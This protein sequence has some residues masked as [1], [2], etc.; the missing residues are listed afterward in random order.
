MNRF[1]PHGTHARAISASMTPSAR[2]G[3]AEFRE[4]VVAD[5]R[6]ADDVTLSEAKMQIER[7]RLIMRM[8]AQID[9]MLSDRSEGP[10]TV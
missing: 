5:Y 9:E 4:G 8:V 1:N 7:V 10:V 6:L 2:G 3:T